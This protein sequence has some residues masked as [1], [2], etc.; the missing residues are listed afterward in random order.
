MKRFAFFGHYLNWGSVYELSGPIGQLLAYAPLGI[1]ER[2]INTFHA[3]KVVEFPILVSKTGSSIMGCGLVVPFLPGHIAMYG[4]RHVLKK[5]IEAGKLAERLGA[6]IIGLAGFTSIPGNEGLEVAKSLGI[7]VTSGNTLTAAL[8]LQGIRKAAALLDLDLRDSIVAIIGATGD[9]GGAC[10]RILS[11]EVKQLRLAARNEERIGAFALTLSEGNDIDVRV[12]NYVKEAVQNA[13]IVLLA[14][15]S[16]TT[17][18]EPCMVKSGAILC[19]IAVPH[20]VGIDVAR[21]RRDVLVFEGGLARLPTRCLPQVGAW[22]HISQDG[23]TIFGCLAET[24]ALAFENRFESYSLGRGNITAARI[25]EIESIAARH[26]IEL[27]EFRYDDVVYTEES[28]TAI[29]RSK[30]QNPR[31]SIRVN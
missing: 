9:I 25:H 14:T 19:D 2:V 10:A 18:I 22:R 3:R 13:D 8:A 7:P 11:T 1:R 15:S 31:H 17:L 23:L 5:I 30:C 6:K 24:M 26:G 21:Q 29:A 12:V 28:I 27:A 20:N 4:E 16:L